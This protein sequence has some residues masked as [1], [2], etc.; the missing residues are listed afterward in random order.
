MGKEALDAAFARG[1]AEDRALLMPYLVTGYPDGDAFVACA[2]AAAAAGADALEIGIPFS[3]PIMD[4]PVIAAASGSV[5]ERGQRTEEALD[6]FAGASQAAGVPLIA[7][8]YYNVVF[9]YGLERFAKTVA[10]RGGAGVILPDLSVEDA[11]PWRAACEDAG[12]AAVFMASQ[13]SPPERL[14]MIGSAAS[15]FVYAAALLGVTG[16]RETLGAQAGP[17]VERIRAATDLPVAVGIGVSTAE[18]AAQV[19][20]FADGVIV[21]SALVKAIGEAVDPSVATAELV[22]RL[23][24]AC[25]R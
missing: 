11:G 1:R 16:V 22:S 18:H 9:R 21:G 12:I 2:G 8:T 14:S 17:L 7:M 6:L 15:G 10:E 13:T 24:P 5:L 19:A 25:A 20:A 3:D 23:K 4:G